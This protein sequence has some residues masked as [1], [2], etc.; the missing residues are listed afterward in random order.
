M[1]NILQFFCR[2]SR[3]QMSVAARIVAT[4]LCIATLATAEVL[5]GGKKMTE[6][7][8]LDAEHLLGEGAIDKL[9]QHDPWRHWP[10]GRPA[11]SAG[12][13][14]RHRARRPI[15]LRGGIIGAEIEWA[16]TIPITGPRYR[17][18]AGERIFIRHG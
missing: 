16:A 13:R 1:W 8:A 14:R 11:G 10:A 3:E 6:G 7:Q 5:L 4:A 18:V 17:P 2:A 15:P 12:Q 9:A